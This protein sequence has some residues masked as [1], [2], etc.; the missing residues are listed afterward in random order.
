MLLI[1][2]QN[3]F[4]FIVLVLIT[5]VKSSLFM[6]IKSC[7]IMYAFITKIKLNLLEGPL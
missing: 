1:N 6:F 4:I 5:T 2:E 3:L 7:R